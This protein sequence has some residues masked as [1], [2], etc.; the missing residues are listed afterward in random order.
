MSIDATT[1]CLWHLLR[2]CHCNWAIPPLSICWSLLFL[3]LIPTHLLKQKQCAV[4]PV[5]FHF[6]KTWRGDIPWCSIV[7][8]EKEGWNNG[9]Y[10][11]VGNMYNNK[12]NQ[13]NNSIKLILQHIMWYTSVTPLKFLISFFDFY[14]FNQIK[15]CAVPP[16]SF[17][18][19]ISWGQLA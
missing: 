5:S 13:C 17:C 19:D 14:L 10:G 1:S 2:Q 4:P 6:Q 8:Q 3:S 16:E 18:G 9:V 15:T 11:I 7:L 12:N